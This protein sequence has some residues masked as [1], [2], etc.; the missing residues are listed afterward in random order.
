MNLLRQIDDGRAEVANEYKSVVKPEGNLAAQKVLAQVYE[1]VDAEWRGLGT[2]PKSGLRMRAEFAEFDAEKVLPVEI[3]KAA[4]RTACRCGEVLRG[5]IKPVE[6]PL[7]GKI[8]E[9]L[10]AVGPCMI[11]VEGVCAAWYKYGGLR[12]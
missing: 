12:L 5:V 4:R 9:P 11:S 1:P 2:I 10:H 8:C 6:C 7:F 3:K